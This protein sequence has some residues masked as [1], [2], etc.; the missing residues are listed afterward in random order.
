MFAAILLLATTMA[1]FGVLGYLK[2]SKWAFISL[3]ILLVA[4]VLVEY[5][6]DTIVA[7][8]NGLYLGV[9]LTLKGGLGALASG[10]LEAA[11]ATLEDIE[12][13]FTDQNQNLALLLVI[14]GAVAIGLI[15][16]AVMKSKAGVFGM[17]WGL[18]YGYV[19]SAAVLPL[20]SSD[21]AAAIPVPLLRPVEREPGAAAAQAS[22]TLDQI[23]TNLAQPQTVQIL[24]I[25]IGA[26]IVLLLL[27]TVRSGVKGGAKKKG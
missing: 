10:D 14:L 20:I 19:L 1:I 3:L 6:P 2:G 5:R 12:R 8:I 26:F 11:K 17:I 13:P 22:S 4:F 24:G 18:V 27:L 9:M 21:P 25:V 7:T 15:L 23:F 16:A